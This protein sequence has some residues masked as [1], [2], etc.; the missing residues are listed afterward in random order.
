MV[1]WVLQ[2]SQVKQ[3][4]EYSAALGVEPTV[5]Q[6]YRCHV[7]LVNIPVQRCLRTLLADASFYGICCHRFK[8]CCWWSSC[9][10]TCTLRHVR[11]FVRPNLSPWTSLCSIT[12]QASREVDEYRYVLCH[13]SSDRSRIE[14]PLFDNS[15]VFGVVLPLHPTRSAKVRSDGLKVV[16]ISWDRC[17]RLLTSFEIWSTV[18]CYESCP[19]SL[20]ILLIAKCTK[21]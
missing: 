7:S 17:H 4:V 6:Q 1:T 21:N 5:H 18:R 13:L 15:L 3:R 14:S 11:A 12:K 9:V 20:L 10:T 2:A 16:A 19:S 8:L